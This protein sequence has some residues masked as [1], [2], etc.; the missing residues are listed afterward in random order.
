MVYDRIPEHRRVLVAHRGGSFTRGFIGAEG[1]STGLA[2]G[3]AAWPRTGA[4]TVANFG[5]KRRTDQR[6]GGDGIQESSTEVA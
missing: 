5:A 6:V 2:Y 3:F 1:C 4:C